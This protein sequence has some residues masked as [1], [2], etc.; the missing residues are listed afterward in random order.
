MILCDMDGVLATGRGMDTARGEPIYRTFTEP[1]AEL[2]RIRADD[3]PFH[4]VT[5]KVE[6]EATQVLRAVGLDGHIAS[7]IGADRLFW[8]TVWTAVRRR[9]L[10]SSL[11]KSVYR[12]VLPTRQDQRVVM[13]EDRHE[14]LSDML[15][16]NVI[17]FGILVPPIS[18]TDDRITEWFDLNLALWV[19]R[20]L[21]TGRV[22]AAELSR[23]SISMYRWQGGGPKELDL[24]DLPVGFGGGGYLLHLPNLSFDPPSAGPTLE[25]LNTGRILKPGRPN[26][27][28]TVRAGRRAFRQIVGRFSSS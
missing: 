13:I 7:V 10:P 9:R 25:T 26:V 28:T 6:A 15:A 16:A 23:R 2:E 5:A 11:T 1:P 8:P 19:A 27:V 14:H 18:I 4:V 24:A 22:V 3:I 12:R 17:D 21:V 20:K